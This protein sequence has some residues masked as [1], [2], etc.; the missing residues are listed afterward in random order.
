MTGQELKLLKRLKQRK[1]TIQVAHPKVVVR[2]YND[3]WFNFTFELVNGDLYNDMLEAVQVQIAESGSTLHKKE[4][5]AMFLLKMIDLEKML[6]NK[7]LSRI[8]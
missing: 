8:K 7:T 2:C 4:M 3:P 5:D 1:I 6:T